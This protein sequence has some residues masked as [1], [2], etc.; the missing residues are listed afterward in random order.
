MSLMKILLRNLVCVF[1]A[2]W[3]WIGLGDGQGGMVTVAEALGRMTKS[4]PRL[5][6]RGLDDFAQI[7]DRASRNE[8]MGYVRKMVL[9]F[10]DDWLTKPPKRGMHGMRMTGQGEFAESV[11]SLAMAWR[12]TG[13][14]KYGEACRTYMLDVCAWPDWNPNHYLDVA[15]MLMGL[16]VG[17]DWAYDALSD[18]ERAIIRKAMIEKGFETRNVNGWWKKAS[19]NWPQVCWGAI[20][21]TAVAIG[22][23]EPEKALEMLE[24]MR[25]SI[26]PCL[27]VYA[28]RG[29][30]PEGPGYWGYGTGRFVYMLAAF[31]VAFGT[32]FKLFDK[33]GFPQ[34]GDFIDAMTGPSG[35]LWNFSDG[36]WVRRVRV[37]DAYLARKTGRRG[38]LAF[39]LAQLR[40]AAEQNA[41]CKHISSMMDEYLAFWLLWG[42]FTP[43][44]ELDAGPL[45]YASGGRNP[46][47]VMRSSRDDNAAYLGLKGGKSCANHGHMDQG[48]VLW[49][50]DGYRWAMDI[51]P[52][53]YTKLEKA[54]I[55]LWNVSQ[56][57]DRWKIFRMNNQ[58]H[59]LVTVDGKLFSVTGFCDFVSTSFGPDVAT[60]TL[61]LSPAVSPYASRGGRRCSLDRKTRIGTVEDAL[62]GLRPG[63]E[64]RWTLVSEA[65]FVRIRGND[66]VLQNEK[67]DS[68]TLRCEA[69]SSV[70]W[71]AVDMSFKPN[72]WDNRN[73]G[74]VLC[75]FT[76]KASADGRYRSRVKFIPGTAKDAILS[77]ED[78]R[79]EVVLGK[80]A[81]DFGPVYNL[82]WVSQIPEKIAEAHSN[83]YKRVVFTGNIRKLTWAGVQK[84]R[85]AGV[86][87]YLEPGRL[88]QTLRIA[89]LVGADG[90]ALEKKGH[91]DAFAER[92]GAKSVKF[93]FTPQQ[94]DK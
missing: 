65:P 48:S 85:A 12:L 39:D 18:D 93:D 82:K 63:A 92:L 16:S 78:V 54:G 62:E 60:A 9:S 3:A 27:A 36:H 35:R 55:N 73:D 23:E 32:T 80:R 4:H 40:R 53:D 20:A 86:K 50:S 24:E 17:Y 41:D 47:V 31:D 57:G 66:L 75:T 51:G 7:N 83:G 42:D 30:Y 56:T 70:T 79:L 10:A 21:L 43:V 61:D 11:V 8:L 94:G 26:P 44:S 28:P 71:Q 90:I 59:N 38:I 67:G 1:F 33:P 25:R 76:A 37:C 68:L 72:P 2:F 77:G 14:R 52:Q 34:T 69:P 15:D 64:V 81:D 45:D 91:L 5:L 29:A 58:S 46:V 89:A 87:T 6:V 74:W 13:D 22:A 49:E 84:L 88:E 19:N